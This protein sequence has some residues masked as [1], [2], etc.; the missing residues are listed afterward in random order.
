MIEDKKKGKTYGSNT[1]GPHVVEGMAVDGSNVVDL[2][3]APTK[4]KSDEQPPSICSWC[5]TVEHACNEHN[6]CLLNVKPKGKHYKPENIG[7]KC[8]LCNVLFVY[9]NLFACLT[10]GSI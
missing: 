6:K 4:N 9:V 8:K 2:V 3:E 5:H 1:A 10:I 7:A